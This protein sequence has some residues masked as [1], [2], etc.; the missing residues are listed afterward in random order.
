[1]IATTNRR[2]R[3]SARVHTL[4]SALRT[5]T[6]CLVCGFAEVRTDEV[7]DRGVLLLNECPRCDHR[8]TERPAAP[9]VRVV[10]DVD[11]PLAA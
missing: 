7:V 4:T 9:V 10:H 2:T 6:R 1:M 8:W 3:A 11:P 5:L